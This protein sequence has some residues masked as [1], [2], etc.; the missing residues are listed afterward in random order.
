MYMHYYITYP[1]SKV[2]AVVRKLVCRSRCT[3]LFQKEYWVPK[4]D[5]ENSC[6]NLRVRVTGIYMYMNRELVYDN[7]DVQV[8]WGN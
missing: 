5:M 3:F 1:K 4:K 7:H 6:S 8:C 2:A